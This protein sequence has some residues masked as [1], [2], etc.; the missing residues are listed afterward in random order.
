MRSGVAARGPPLQSR[1]REAELRNL[2]L[3]GQ[4]LRLVL[5]AKRVVSIP[6]IDRR[7]LLYAFNGSAVGC[8]ADVP[9]I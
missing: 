6:L 8:H 5:I 3:L 7:D 1:V 4:L 2:S 9:V